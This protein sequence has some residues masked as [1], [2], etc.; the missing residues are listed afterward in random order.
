MGGHITVFRRALYSKF[1]RKDLDPESFGRFVDIDDDLKP[2][3]AEDHGSFM[4]MIKE[5]S[6]YYPCSPCSFINI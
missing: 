2:E 6:V 1:S 3:H 5:Y 4:P